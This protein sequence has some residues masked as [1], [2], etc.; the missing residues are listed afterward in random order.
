MGLVFGIWVRQGSLVHVTGL[1][2]FGGLRLFL[3]RQKST[4]EKKNIWVF[5]ACLENMPSVFFHNLFVLVFCQ[6]CLSL[7]LN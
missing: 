7:I 5:K 4:K 2:L 6:T 3:A 1:S